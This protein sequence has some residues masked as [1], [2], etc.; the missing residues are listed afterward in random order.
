MKSLTVQ[1]RLILLLTLLLIISFICLTIGASLLNYSQT[2]T[3]NEERLKTAMESF[4]REFDRGI[5][6][7]KRLFHESFTN[8]LEIT[9]AFKAMVL[10]DDSDIQVPTKM[11]EIGTLLHATRLAFYY[12]VEGHNKLRLRLYYDRE[13][14]GTSQMYVEDETLKRRL[15]QKNTEGLITVSEI[16]EAPQSLSM[17]FP[18]F[19]QPYFLQVKNGV[20]LLIADLPYISAFNDVNYN[21][22]QGEELGRFVLEKPLELNLQELDNDLGVHFTVYDRHG[23]M[24]QGEVHMPDLDLI[25]GK[26]VFSNEHVIEL[27][28]TDGNTYD[29]MLMPLTYQHVTVGYVSANI[30]QKKRFQKIGETVRVLFLIALVVVV[31]AAMLLS[32]VV[33]RIIAHPL[34]HMA[35][36]ARSQLEGDLD[37]RIELVTNDEYGQL[38]QTFNMLSNKLSKILQEQQ[39][40]ITDL[41]QVKEALRRQ[42]EELATLQATVLDITTPHDLPTL[43]QT[44]VERAA[45]LLD[46]LG[47]GMYLC[48]PIQEEVRCVV[49]Y[50]TPRDYTGMVLKYGE[51]ASGTV[52]QTGDPLIID[53]YRIWPGRAVA[54]E[55]E[56]PFTAVLAAPMIWENQVIG[57]IDLLHNVTSRR[58]TQTDLKLLTLFANHAAIAVENTRLYEQAQQEIAERRRAEEMLRI[59]DYAIASSL[60][61]IVI[62]EFAGKLTYVNP[63]FLK[64]W[65]YHDEDEILGRPAVDF[66]QRQEKA[67]EVI[68]A[69]RVEGSWMGELA[70][71]RKDGTLFDV[72]LAASLVTD[73]TGKPICMMASFMDITDRKRAE[74]ALKESEERF[75]GIVERNFD[76]IASVDMEGRLTYISPAVERIL[77]YKPEEVIGKHFQN[78][79]PESDIPRA[80]QAFIEVSKGGS[81][82]GVQLKLLRKD[83]FPIY[84]ETNSSPILKDGVI[85][86]IQGI[87]RDITERRR[88]EEQL[89]NQNLLLEQAVQEKQRE[90]EILFERLLRQEKLATIGQMAGSVAHELRNPLGAVKNSV[91]F[92][93]RLWQKQNLDASNPKVKEHLE[94]I[95]AEINTSERVISN[96][97]QMTRM[98][99]LQREQTDL[100][101]I[102]VD[103]AEHSHLPENIHLTIKLQPD[104]F[105]IWAD[106]GQ[107]RQVFIN[108]L[109]NAIQA[110]AQ[111]GNITIKAKQL[112][113]EKSTIIEIENDGLGIEPDALSKVFEPLYTTKTTGTGLGL[114]IC[115]QI[116]E[117]HQGQISVSSQVGQGTTVTIILPGQDSHDPGLEKQKE[118]PYHKQS[119]T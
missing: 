106:P 101:P 77:G 105:I 75:R 56:Q 55:E 21:L 85:V 88:A 60:S 119:G 94:L 43:L 44:I 36:V 31:I 13:L 103:A 16:S 104:P 98:K 41:K 46:A 35:V 112:A 92:L 102:I 37:A 84:V 49:S 19:E 27:S 114:S 57:V 87:Y 73:E 111:D 78:F 65:G 59:K 2:R 39:I 69:L 53:D 74:Q 9:L 79:F 50:N 91:F 5:A 38:G 34:K 118:E 67:R 17:T 86:G 47:G 15:I 48:D 80:V 3:Q 45:R 7:D 18:T 108:I 28:D 76:A 95:E 54:F 23:T 20:L 113:K 61:A 110:I 25:Q 96:L 52:A 22:Q 72:Q 83:G 116:I 6:N 51:G 93:K 68:E 90:M 62:A 12:Q 33:V 71:K 117:N 63:S 42:A 70:A 99:P 11:M 89:K 30:S 4:Q 26:K 109:T 81:T 1:T 29:S 97:L 107:L 10:I 8:I 100:Y 82:K 24:G 66:W 32:L 64:M 58:F 40:T 115:K 14:G